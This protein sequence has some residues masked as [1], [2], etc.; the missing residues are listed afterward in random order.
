MKERAPGS[1]GTRLDMVTCL[2]QSGNMLMPFSVLDQLVDWP[3]QSGR[4]VGDGG[5]V[6]VIR[7][8]AADFFCICLFFKKNT[9]KL[10]SDLFLHLDHSLGA[11]SYDTEIAR[12]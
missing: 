4:P 12:H 3:T 1:G 5:D 11:I 10:M 9:F 2:V 6:Q 8:A 7:V